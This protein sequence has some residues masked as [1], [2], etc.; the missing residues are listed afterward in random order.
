MGNDPLLSVLHLAM[1]IAY[2]LEYSKSSW[3]GNE[4]ENKFPNQNVD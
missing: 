3:T 1:Y 4:G 2:I